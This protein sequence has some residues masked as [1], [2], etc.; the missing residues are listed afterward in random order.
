MNQE[1]LKLFS[2]QPEKLL[3]PVQQ[4]AELSL[5]NSEKLLTMQLEVAQSYVHLSVSQ[6]KALFEVKDA[7]SLQAYV[8][9]QA[10]VAKNVGQKLMADAKAVANLGAEF[11]AETQKLTQESLK[12]V[13]SNNA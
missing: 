12:V 3:A 13:A 2:V 10:D 4:F 5:V 1:L 7:V 9:S 8:S 6:L 11:N